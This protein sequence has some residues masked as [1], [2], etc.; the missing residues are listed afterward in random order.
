[1]R[2]GS[3][4]GSIMIMLDKEGKQKLKTHIGNEGQPTYANNE[5]MVKQCQR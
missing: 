5:E 1:M 2:Q 3:R 4:L